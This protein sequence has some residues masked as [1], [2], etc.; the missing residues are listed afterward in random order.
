[1]KTYWEV[2]VQFHAFLISVLDR[3][4]LSASRPNRFTPGERIL[5]YS[6]DRRLGGLQSQSGCGG[7]DKNF[8][9][10]PRIE[11]QSSSP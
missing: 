5:W 7:E 2:E 4:Y 3:G 1:M 6:L 9:P 10:L 8:Q 11:S